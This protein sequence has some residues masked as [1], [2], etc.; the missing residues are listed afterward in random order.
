MI[1]AIL[2]IIFLVLHLVAVNV[3]D[4]NPFYKGRNFFLF[5]TVCILVGHVYGK[6]LTGGP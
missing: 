2:C 1:W 4:T 3:A 5:L 6:F